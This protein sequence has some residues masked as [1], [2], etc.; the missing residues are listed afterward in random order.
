MSQEH[1]NPQKGGIADILHEVLDT[2]VLQA[3]KVQI[4]EDGFFAASLVAQ[5][6]TDPMK[7]LDAFNQRA[8]E[9]K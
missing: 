7:I 5:G 3:K 2:E 6:V 4:L 8:A 1:I 9:L